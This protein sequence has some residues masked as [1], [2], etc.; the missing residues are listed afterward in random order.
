M[1]LRTLGSGLCLALALSL[2]A[3]RTD[4]PPPVD[5]C[6]GDGFGGCNG[7]K[8]TGEH[9]DK[10]PSELENAFVIPDPRQAEAFIKWCYNP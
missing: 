6:H 5:L 10:L 4:K 9:F 3:C 1:R 7:T 8:A 2:S